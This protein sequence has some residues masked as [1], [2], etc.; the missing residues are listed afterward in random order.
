MSD[1][2]TVRIEN[3]YEDGHESTHEV[4]VPVPDDSLEG[5]WDEVSSWTG[6]GHGIGKDLGYCYTAT[7]IDAPEPFRHL[8]GQTEEWSGK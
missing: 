1:L 8:I 6:D 3:N 5:W 4:L 2:I 7:V